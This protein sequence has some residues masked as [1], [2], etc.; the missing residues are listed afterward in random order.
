MKITERSVKV[1][2]RNSYANGGFKYVR[3]YVCMGPAANGIGFRR[4]YGKIG[5]YEISF[6]I[7]DL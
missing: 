7:P 5:N 3:L 2:L 1:L 6:R 4:E